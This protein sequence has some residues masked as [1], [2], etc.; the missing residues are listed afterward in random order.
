MNTVATRREFLSTVALTTAA[1]LGGLPMIR[2]SAA[3]ALAD[4]PAAGSG[5]RI[6][7]AKFAHE[8]NTF[9]PLRTTRFEFPEPRLDNPEHHFRWKDAGE[10]VIPGVSALPD[11][12]GTIDGAACREAMGRILKSL[13]AA[14]PVDGVFLQVHGAM[15]VDGVGPAETVMVEQVRSVVGPNVPIACSFDLHGNIP[16]RLAQAGDILVGFKTAPHTDR[17]ETIEHAARLLAETLQGKVKPVSCVVPIPM[18]LPGEK[19]MTTAE[20]FHSLVEEARRLEREGVPGHAA[21][22]LA[23]TLFVGCAWTDSADTGMAAVVTADGSPAAARAAAVYLAHKVWAAR[24]DFVYGCETAELADGVA[25]AMRAKES[26]IFLTDSGDNVTASAPGDLPIVLRHLIEQK[27]SRAI[28]AGI[29]DE[30]AVARCFEAGPGKTLH[31]SIGAT[32]EKRFGPPLTGDVEVLRLVNEKPRMAVVRIGGVEA[33]LIDRDR[34]FVDLQ[35]FRSCG[36]DP[37]AYK[38]VVVKQGYLYPKLTKIA[39]RHI[40]LL[41]PG[42][43]DMRL[44]KLNYV[45]RRRPLFPLEPDTTFN[46]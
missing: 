46:P 6:F 32:I 9:H 11:G 26:T 22:I 25:K 34:A 2:T 29:L 45:R 23:A 36:L 10:V 41:T 15:Y 31:L 30:A 1:S 28:V 37:L 39:P 20:P 38:L 12:G 8:T 40:M 27:A 13:R 21:K 43:A 17:Q 5:K 3:T 33:I 35:G 7:V 42:A 14:M 19:A 18:I 4:E 16:A 44:D 24:H